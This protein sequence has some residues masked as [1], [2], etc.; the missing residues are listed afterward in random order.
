[1]DRVKMSVE[2]R[3]VGKDGDW[4]A[5]SFWLA[6]RDVVDGWM[7]VDGVATLPN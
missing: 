5:G 1:V 2:A 4:V 6:C 3:I 7:M